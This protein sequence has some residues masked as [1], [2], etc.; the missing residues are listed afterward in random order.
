MPTRGLWYLDFA[1]KG[2]LGVKLG[3]RLGEG[4]LPRLQSLPNS[5]SSPGPNAGSDQNELLPG[6]RPAQ[7]E[8]ITG[9]KGLLEVICAATD[10]DTGYQPCSA[11]ECVLCLDLLPGNG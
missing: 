9:G 8:L 10:A 11:Q 4:A 5:Q 6:T 1:P 2:A 3:P 7:R